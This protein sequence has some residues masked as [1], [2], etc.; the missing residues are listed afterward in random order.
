MKNETEISIV[1][2]VYNEAGNINGLLDK[3]RHTMDEITSSYEIV[4]VDDGSADATGVE[5]A[6]AA[7]DDKKIKVLSLSR[8]FGK[9]IA[10]CAG[11]DH[12]SGEAVVTM[13]GD[14]QHPPETIKLMLAEWKNGAD[15]VTALRSD[16][17]SG[18]IL[19][20]AFSRW[21][22]NTFNKVSEININPHAGDFR[23]FDRRVVDVIKSLPERTRFNKGLFAWVGFDEKFVEFDVADR[24][25]GSSKWGLW[26]LWNFALDGIFSFSTAPLRIW[27]YVGMIVAFFSFLYGFY[28]I[29]QTLVYGIDV[30]GYASVI[31]LILFFSGL[32]LIGLGIVGEYL[33][34][35]FIEAKG[36]PLYII[37]T[38]ENFDENP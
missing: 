10:L 4:F 14:L 1:I 33:G 12:A 38:M 36:R 15:M 37:K 18:S 9:E 35:A 3:L 23:L 13:D 25:V 16:R 20:D 17:Q 34:R 31:V 11:L 21:F 32:N 6:N 2:P 22:Y 7:R 30:P 24:T 5:L 26:R 8:N 29:G 28:I 27:T 19:K